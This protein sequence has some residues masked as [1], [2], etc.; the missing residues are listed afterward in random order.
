M[1]RNRRLMNQINVVPYIDVMLVLLVIFMVTAPMIQTGSVDLPSVGKASEVPAEPL[2][3]EVGADGA[4]KLRD[5]A[6]VQSLDLATIIAQVQ[7]AQPRPVLIAGD[8]K[9]SYDDVLKVMSQLQSA[10]IDKI[11]LLVQRGDTG[12][13]RKK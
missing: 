7:A 6:D 13:A 8:G 4:L 10:S 11:G 9:A 2:Q 5:K 3:I 12:P 1:A